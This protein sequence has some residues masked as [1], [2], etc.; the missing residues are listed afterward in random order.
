MKKKVIAGFRSAIAATLA[1]IMI[2]SSTVQTSAEPLKLEHA[3]QNQGAST[4]LQKV[5]DNQT[6]G[7]NSTVSEAGVSPSGEPGAAS[8]ITNTSDQNRRTS[9]TVPSIP[10][11]SNVVLP[12]SSTSFNTA[13]AGLLISDDATLDQEMVAKSMEQV[14]TNSGIWVPASARNDILNLLN[15]ASAYPF[16]IDGDGYIHKIRDSILTSQKSLTFYNKIDALISG[17]DRIILSISPYYWSYNESSHTITKQE[18][19]DSVSV[20]F[21]DS[22]IMILDRAHFAPKSQNEY[23]ALAIFMLNTLYKDGT[24][25][26][27]AVSKELS[28][29][30]EKAASSSSNST[31]LPSSNSTSSQDFS[32]VSGNSS[33]T[34]SDASS[35]NSSSPKKDAGDDGSNREPSGSP[36]TSGSSVDSSS[37]IS[38][39]ASS[40][41]QVSGKTENVFSSGSVSSSERDSLQDEQ[42]DKTFSN[43]VSSS[44]SVD[45]KTNPPAKTDA[46]SAVSSGSSQLSPPSKSGSDS[47]IPSA[48]SDNSSSNSTGS[49]SYPSVSS[50]SSGSQAPSQASS[51]SNNSSDKTDDSSSTKH[52][53]HFSR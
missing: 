16:T 5:P 22:R 4:I 33:Q 32:N 38:T 10:Q 15:A 52:C 50:Q 41:S 49:R 25:Y 43:T 21:H 2:F 37:Q 39:S 27:S 9:G 48:A 29:I 8:G 30:L 24:D 26:T 45:V 47:S 6:P 46:A 7:T 44:R 34:Q 18:I 51:A 3:R 11:K 13:L 42:K 35:G 31:V 20:V 17:Q 14:P 40:A 1:T 19:S 53:Q 28:S 23:P 12:T 36:K